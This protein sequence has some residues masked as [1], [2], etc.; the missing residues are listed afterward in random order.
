MNG[1]QTRCSGTGFCWG[2][3][4]LLQYRAIVTD[5]HHPVAQK[6]EPWGN[7]RFNLVGFQVSDEG[8]RHGGPEEKN[9]V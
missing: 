5:G 6:I 8:V 2:T 1:A 9:T 4:R 7:R 3:E